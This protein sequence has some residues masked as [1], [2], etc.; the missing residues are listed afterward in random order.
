MKMAVG[1]LHL[2]PILNFIFR[3]LPPEVAA[4]LRSYF[5][6]KCTSLHLSGTAFFPFVHKPSHLTGHGRPVWPIKVT[7]VY[8]YNYTLHIVP[9]CT[10]EY[11]D[12]TD[13]VTIPGRGQDAQSGFQYEKSGMSLLGGRTLASQKLCLTERVIFFL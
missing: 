2:L 8:I 9:R 5:Y 10:A 13:N 7:K 3:P 4:D 6:I 11:R 1:Y 12:Y